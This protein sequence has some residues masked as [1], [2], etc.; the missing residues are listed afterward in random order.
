MSPWMVMFWWFLAVAAGGSLMVGMIA[1]KRP[2]P[3]AISMGHG[4]F[5]LV[6]VGA[7]FTVNLWGEAQTPELAWW[8]FGVLTAGLIGGL[9]F[10]RV[11]FK[12]KAP[13]WLALGHGSVGVVGLVLLYNAAA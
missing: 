7:L 12:D 2:I 9:L 4:L 13:L 3:R 11:L 5:A 1:T 6:A 10:F 8:A